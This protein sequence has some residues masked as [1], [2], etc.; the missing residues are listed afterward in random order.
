MAAGFAVGSAKC[1]G[2]W[3][4]SV[5]ARPPSSID[6]LR[7]T[8]ARTD[9]HITRV[10]GR[11]WKQKP[12][13]QAFRSASGGALSSCVMRPAKEPNTKKIILAAAV[14]AASTG[15]FAKLPLIN[16]SCPT[17][18]SVHVDEGGPVY[19][20]GKEAQ[21]KRFND[22]DYEA[23]QGNAV[24]SININLDGSPGVSYTRS[25]ANGICTIKPD[26][27]PA[28]TPAATPS[29]H[30]PQGKG[31]PVSAGNMPAFCRGEASS[32]Y[33]TRPTYIKTGNLAKAAGSYPVKG[34]VDKSNE[35]MKSFV[36]S[37]DAHCRFIEVQPQDSDGE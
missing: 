3:Q 12:W 23:R 4:D 33:G 14:L 5:P 36:C 6:G 34:T 19:V 22:N 18:I 28:H 27:A 20:N 25:K 16:A 8:L 21:I 15:A 9:V 26:A 1:R 13:L 31:D 7:A 32:L 24:V 35:G 17:D 11:R 2:R 29:A 30:G 37:F 10:I